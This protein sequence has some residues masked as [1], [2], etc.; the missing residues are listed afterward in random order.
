MALSLSARRWVGKWWTAA[1]K[2]KLVRRKNPKP[3]PKIE[4]D[5]NRKFF[6]ENRREGLFS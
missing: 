6:R 3:L 1:Q 4:K 5:T 2:L